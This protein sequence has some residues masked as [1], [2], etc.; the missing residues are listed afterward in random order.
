MPGTA[1][2]LSEPL[3]T[4]PAHAVAAG[5]STVAIGVTLTTVTNG[6]SD[7]PGIVSAIAAASIALG[8]LVVAAGTYRMLNMTGAATRRTRR[9]LALQGI[10]L[11]GLTIGALVLSLLQSLS[12][13]YAVSGLLIVMSGALGVSGALLLGRSHRASWLLAGMSLLAAGVLVTFLSS[14]AEYFFFSDVQ[15]AVAT[16]AG[17]ALTAVGCILVAYWFNVSAIHQPANGAGRTPGPRWQGDADH[18]NPVD[19]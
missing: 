17:E 6:T 11:V 3:H 18:G 1:D 14:V 7:V 13:L 16:D 12:A 5:Y 9:G 2:W 10:A 8:V 15:G 19:R 4:A